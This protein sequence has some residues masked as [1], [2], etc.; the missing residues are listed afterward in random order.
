[1]ISFIFYGM[2]C[3]LLIVFLKSRKAKVSMF[4]IAI[5]IIS[6]IGISRI[7]LGVHYPSDVMAGYAAG[8][9]WLTICLM[10]LKLVLE[11]RKRSNN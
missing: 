5:F 4:L 7:Y 11:S 6:A 9:A 1:M 8:G 3:M 10:G 2:L